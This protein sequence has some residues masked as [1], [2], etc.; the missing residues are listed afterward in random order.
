MSWKTCK[1]TKIGYRKLKGQSGWKKIE[2][3]KDMQSVYVEGKGTRIVIT[4]WKM[5]IK[6]ERESVCPTSTLTIYLE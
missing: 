6:W 3:V 5:R 1:E 2:K 4:I